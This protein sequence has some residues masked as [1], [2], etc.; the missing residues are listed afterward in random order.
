MAVGERFASEIDSRKSRVKLPQ[1]FASIEK[2][3]TNESKTSNP[4]YNFRKSQIGE[5]FEKEIRPNLPRELSERAEM[6]FTGVLA[7]KNWR[8][9]NARQ[10]DL[11]EREMGLQVLD[12]DTIQG[13]VLQSIKPEEF[14]Q[15]VPVAFSGWA[16]RLTDATK[17]V[18]HIAQANDFIGEKIANHF[19]SLGINKVK[20][21]DL[22]AGTGA[23]MLTVETN[24]KGG[25][26]IEVD[27]QGVDL[28]PNLA[29]IASERTGRNV[30]VGNFLDW[31][32]KQPDESL[33]F[34][35]IVYAIHHLHYDDQLKLQTEAYKK[36]KKNG[37]FALADP[38][39]R[40]TFNLQNLDINEPEAIM[41][42]FRPYVDRVADSLQNE[43]FYVEKE[44]DKRIGKLSVSSNGIESTISGNVLD[45]GTLGYAVVAI[46]P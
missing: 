16:D 25:A 17:Q 14:P 38:T 22:G 36:L 35:T 3:L 32:K 15:F 12:A 10:K 37:V 4:I 21:V 7:L 9:N 30:E 11:G 28:T 34:I 33:D 8:D 40:S 18:P 19:K 46:K 44:N 2:F 13:W 41:A 27:L 45:Q 20:G 24:L 5:R 42:C 39:G 43:E 23:T 29:K 1:S 6:V 31:L 26:Q